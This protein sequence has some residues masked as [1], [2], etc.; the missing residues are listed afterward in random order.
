MWEVL[1]KIIAHAI[2]TYFMSC[3]KVLD[4]LCTEWPSYEY[5][6]TSNCKVQFDGAKFGGINVVGIGVFA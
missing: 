1:S 5:D 2:L 6:I 4:N 3:F